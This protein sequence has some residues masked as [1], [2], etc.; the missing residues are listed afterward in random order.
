[1]IKV[2]NQGVIRKLAWRSF[3]A[4]RTRNL[5]AIM[6]IALTSILFSTLFTISSGMVETFQNETMR[7][8]GGMAHA[9]LKYLTPEQ[10]EIIKKHPLIEEIGEN[11]A[12][13]EAANKE[14]LKRRA[15]IW[16]SDDTGAQLGFNYPT[17]GSMPKKENE[18]VC[19]SISLDLLAVPHQVGQKFVLEYTVKN[20]K[21]SRE[22]ILSGFYEGDPVAPAGTILVSRPFIDRELA[23]IKPA[24]RLNSDISGTIRADIVFKN[25]LH[26]EENIRQLITESGFSL[27]QNDPDYIA[28]GVNW[29]YVSASYDW[30]ADTVVPILLTAVLIIFTGYLIIYNI[31]Q[32]SV[33]KDTRFYGLL[34]TIGTTP[35]QIRGLIIRQALL[36]SAVGIPLG[37]LIGWLLGNILLPSIVAISSYQ[38]A[39]VG[40]SPHPLIFLGAALFALLTV[41]ISCR[42]PGRTASRVSPVEAVRYTGIPDQPRRGGKKT[43]GGGRLYKMALSNLGR[44]KKRTL[45]VIISMSLSL[46]LLNT[47]FTVSRGFDM[48]KFLSR[49]VETDFL[50][51]HANYFS[52][53][54]GFH[55]QEDALSEQ[56][57][58]AVEAREGFEGGGRL[59]YNLG[60]SQ[61]SYQG[62]ERYLQLYGLEDL[63]FEQLDIVEGELDLDTFKSGQYIIEAVEEDDYGRISWETSRC[64]I[65]ETVSITTQTG[66]HEYVVAAKCRMKRSNS[67]RYKFSFNG[68]DSFP[69]YLPAAEFRNIVPDAAI[70]SYQFNVDEAHTPAVEEFV[71]GYTQRVEA[72]MNYES[73]ASFTGQFNK[74]QQTLL[75]VGGAMSLIIALIGLLN[76]INSVLTGIIARRQ[77]FAMLQSIGMTDGQLRRLLIYEGLYYALGTMLLSFFLAIGSSWLIVKGLVSQLWFFSYQFI[78]SPLLAAYPFLILLSIII[79]FAAYYGVN[80]QSI[81]ERLREAE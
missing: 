46:I 56:F 15:E 22:M 42:K 12:V 17:S 21:R 54:R 23:G 39:R 53:T 79:P 66:R 48:D 78:I 49:Y 70:M 33:V 7:Q 50:L 28:Y 5:I 30:D 1:M 11:I 64:Q 31:F 60:K 40:V 3:K 20:E 36:L 62:L 29:A 76:F 16:Y 35:R 72:A 80:R 41:F 32:I 14:F 74:L 61:I 73:K 59:Y 18:I 44:S 4:N 71:K 37:L 58:S 38:S 51:A 57:I 10:Y 63:P 27:D 75:L 34:K 25:S 26:I 81:V 45:I 68:I 19:D 65:G 2:K 67:V 55:S 69:L 9:S 47:V 13:G 6:A 24:Y 77:E 52:V 43:T 8:S